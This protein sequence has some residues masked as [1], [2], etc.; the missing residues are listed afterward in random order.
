MS[1]TDASHSIGWSSLAFRYDTTAEEVEGVALESLTADIYFDEDPD[2]DDLERLKGLNLVEMLKEEIDKSNRDM[3]RIKLLFRALKLA[4]PKDAVTLIFDRFDRLLVFTRDMCLLMEALED[5]FNDCFDGLIDKLIKSIVNPPASSVQLIRTWLLEIF[6]RGI[7]L[8]PKNRM[9]EVEQL[10]GVIDKRQLL[11]IR[12]RNN[13]TNYF[14]RQKTAIY[15]FSEF[16]LP[17]AVCGASCL[18]QDE[19]EKWCDTIKSSF[20]KPLGGLFLKW[21]VKNKESLVDKLE[22]SIIDH[23]E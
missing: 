23:P 4:K 7:I 5:E 13:D 6:V 20:T 2:E 16:E 22:S 17:V 14:R 18:P 11:L 10:S 3:R 15:Q 12:G 1:L 21:A 9:K 8:L 19:Y